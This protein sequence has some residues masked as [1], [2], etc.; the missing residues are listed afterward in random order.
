MQDRLDRLEREI[1]IIAGSLRLVTGGAAANG[2]AA[3]IAAS[4]PARPRS[5]ARIGVGPQIVGNTAHADRQ[6]RLAKAKIARRIIA[7]RRGRERTFGHE[8]FA[9]PAW[10]VLLDLY[11]A[12]QE[13]RQVSISSLCIAAAVPATTALRWIKTMTDKGIL[14]RA[15]DEHDGRRIHVHLNA[16]FVATMD[17]F[18]EAQEESGGR[19]PI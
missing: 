14:I 1:D 2:E 15:A 19:L 18:L 8:L 9:D 13:G 5:S 11:A 6:D 10:D 4:L 7:A 16:A 17:E 12:H 3:P